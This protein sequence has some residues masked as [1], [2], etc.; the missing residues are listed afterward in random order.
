MTVSGPG[1]IFSGSIGAHLD[2]I[3]VASGSDSIGAWQEITLYYGFRNSAIRLYD[4]RAIVLFS[5][6]YGEAGPNAAA[7]PHFSSF[8][9]NLF[10]FSYDGVWSYAF[11]SLSTRSPW[12]FYDSQANAFLL[13]PASNFMTA[14]TRFADDGAMEAAIDSRIDGLPAG[15]THRSVLAFGQGINATFDTWGKTLTDLSGKNLPANDSNAILNKLSYWTDA[16]AAYYY[17]PFQGSQYVPLLEQL[18]PEFQRFSTPIGSMELDSWHYPKGTPPSWANN[19]FGLDTFEA[20]PTIFPNGLGAFQRS[21]GLPLIAHTRW[22]DAG[23]PLRSKYV[24]SNFVAIDPQ[25]WKDYAKYLSDSGVEVLEQDWLCGPAYTNFNLTDPYLFLDNMASAMQATGRSI[26]YC[27]PLPAH[28]LQSSNYDN[29]IA[30]RTSNDNFM[31]A[32]WDE[33]LFNSRL[34]SAVGLWP[35]ADAFKS[36][37]Q[38]DVL[39]ATLMAGPVGSGDQL[40]TGNEVNLRHAVRTD[41]VI[42][43]PDISLAPVDATYL[44]FSQSAFSPVVASTYTDHAGLRTGY[45][46][47]YSQ[48]AASALSQISFSP[49]V[50]RVTG[51]AYVYDYFENTGMVIQPGREFHALVNYDGSYYLVAPI[52]PSGIAFL[53]DSGKF[54][55]CGKKRIEQLSDDGTLRVLVRF[56][57]GEEFVALRLYSSTEPTVSADSGSVGSLQNHGENLYRVVVHP[58][59]TGAA[60]LTFRVAAASRA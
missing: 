21:L 38:R 17:Q 1:W 56:A 42:V 32:R 39:V 24:I 27:M 49:A 57:A 26:V 50:A 51:P 11:N 45:V 48:V 31:R 10:T 28:I 7:F 29:V 60:A 3:D 59:S 23:S 34:A 46:L 12:L 19:G 16:G 6:Q 14:V 58:D 41:G 25:Y 2:E 36:K 30:V 4:G 13:S 47:A 35:F 37:N 54:V 20:D 9:Q 44:A 15:F 8:P 22:I 43:K 40:G 53:G 18:P 33:L 52:G 5:T 55:S